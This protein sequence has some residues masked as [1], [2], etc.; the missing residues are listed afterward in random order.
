MHQPSRKD[1]VLAIAVIVTPNV[2]QTARPAVLKWPCNI[3][4]AEKSPE[5]GLYTGLQDFTP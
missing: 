2:M 4:W 5:T 1:Q 3:I